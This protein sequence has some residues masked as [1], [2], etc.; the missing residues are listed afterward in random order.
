[1]ASFSSPLRERLVPS[2]E[3]GTVKSA[4]SAGS[5]RP[6]HDDVANRT[7]EEN[8]TFGMRQNAMEFDA[9]DLDNNRK[10]DFKEFSQLVRERELAVHSDLVLAYRFQELDPE[11]TGYVGIKE[12]LMSSL[13]DALSRSSSTCL[14]LFALFDEDG[15]GEISK[16][17]FRK[18]IRGFGFKATN[19]EIDAVFDQLD[20][21]D[22][23]GT[24]SYLELNRTL[25]T[26]DPLPEDATAREIAISAHMQHPLRRANK[27]FQERLDLSGEEL[28]SADSAEALAEQLRDML[29]KNLT[30]VIDLFRAWD[31]DMSGTIE[32]REFCVAMRCMG[33]KAP[34]KI[35]DE[36]FDDFDRDGSGSVDYHEL[37]KKLRRTIE[38]NE[39][40]RVGAAGEIELEAKNRFSLGRSK[41]HLETN[42]KTLH[43]LVLDPKADLTEQLIA[44]IHESKARVLHLFQEWDTNGD[45]AISKRELF[46]AL[47]HLGLANNELAHRAVESLFSLLDKDGGGTIDFRELFRGMRVGAAERERGAR[48]ITEA[49]GTKPGP[50]VAGGFVPHQRCLQPSFGPHMGAIWNP[51]MSKFVF[52]PL[53]RHPDDPDYDSDEDGEPAEEPP[54]VIFRT[55]PK[56]VYRPRYNVNLLRSA[57]MQG[58]GSTPVKPMMRGSASLAVLPG[59]TRRHPSS[60]TLGAFRLD[61]SSDVPIREQLIR[62]VQAAKQRVLRVFEE[63][64]ED[65]DGTITQTELQSALMQLGLDDAEASKAT[66]ELFSS[67]DADS[68]GAV[69]LNELFK[70]FR[71]SPGKIQSNVGGLWPRNE[72]QLPAPVDPLTFEAGYSAFTS[73]PAPT[74][75]R[76]DT[77]TLKNLFRDAARASKLAVPKMS[78]PPIYDQ[79][80][81]MVRLLRP[82]APALQL[83]VEPSR[84]SRPR[85]LATLRADVH[86][87]DEWYHK[88]QAGRI[89]PAP[90]RAH[91]ATFALTATDL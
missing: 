54:E 52:P 26:K 57:S 77:K 74:G 3:A 16:K 83:G 59:A 9:H 15:N 60:K 41:D 35:I 17:E 73:M 88:A 13:K 23:S 39:K 12:Y 6:L 5:L 8:F 68:S 64:D 38:I 51:H 20:F 69:E 27:D 61:A 14:D 31:E 22:Q 24:L 47:Q 33:V 79:R 81:Q 85:S 71:P 40:L 18:A 72:A 28:Q 55:K 75:G 4:Q 44:A 19:L 56:V 50:Q 58:I 49:A 21:V 78:L 65:G 62:A 87:D 32:K 30:R 36:L 10:L 76:K 67:I 63:W 46:M 70:A 25:R 48:P 91:H 53:R 45:G 89:L 11:N 34:K 2:S 80:P 42:S 66:H 90:V 43:G 84:L 37:N 82:R 29:L 86:S 7:E 1:M